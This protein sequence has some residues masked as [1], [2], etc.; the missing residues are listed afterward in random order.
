MSLNKNNSI[1]RI[2]YLRYCEDITEIEHS[3]IDVTVELENGSKYI[4]VFATLE[5]LQYLMNK[6]KRNYLNPGYPIIIVRTLSK[7]TIIQTIKAYLETADGY[8]LKL[9]HFAADIDPRL[10]KQLEAEAKKVEEDTYKKYNLQ[11]DDK[12]FLK[13]YEVYEGKDLE[14]LDNS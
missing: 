13:L 1:K 12:E 6:G 2:R 7:S 5:N 9:Y 4:L 14:E 10:F 11:L 3:N 8:W